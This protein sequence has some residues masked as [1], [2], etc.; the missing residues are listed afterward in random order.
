M[1]WAWTWS[2]CCFGYWIDDD[3]W[4]YR[5]KHIGRCINNDI[6]AP[7]GR[8]IGELMG[9]SRLITN[10]SKAGRAGPLFVPTRARGLEQRLPD[11]TGNVFY[12]GYGDFPH[13]DEL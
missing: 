11:D 13:P 8:Y 4:T 9:D 2:G 5:G 7:S 10:K 12:K 1:R 3:L 6:Y